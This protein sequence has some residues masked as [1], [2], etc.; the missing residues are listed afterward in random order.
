MGSGFYIRLTTGRKRG[1]RA[2]VW[3][4]AH[5]PDGLRFSTYGSRVLDRNDTDAWLRRACSR[6]GVLSRT[7]GKWQPCVPCCGALLLSLVFRVSPP[8]GCATMFPFRARAGGSVA[9]PLGCRRMENQTKYER[10]KDEGIGGQDCSR[11]KV[12]GRCLTRAVG[13]LLRDSPVFRR[14][15]FCL[16]SARPAGPRLDLKECPGE[17][18]QTSGYSEGTRPECTSEFLLHVPLCRF[19]LLYP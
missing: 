8:L 1:A 3:A 10:T 14:V 11:R 16:D 12:L 6:G 19:L 5:D 7:G 18:M 4:D 17:E 13:R 15:R 2:R 9:R